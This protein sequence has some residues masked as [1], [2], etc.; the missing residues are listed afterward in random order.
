MTRRYIGEYSSTSGKC[1]FINRFFPPPALPPSPI[2]PPF[3]R[4]RGEGNCQCGTWMMIVGAGGGSSGAPV[5]FCRRFLRHHVRNGTGTLVC[6]PSVF[7]YSVSAACSFASFV[8]I[9]LSAAEGAAPARAS[10]RET[11]HPEIQKHESK[12]RSVCLCARA[13]ALSALRR[14]AT[15]Q[16]N[17]P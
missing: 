9:D 11:A 2:S 7:L 6:P 10:E 1:F 4:P 14:T 17:P 13:R 5:S 3:P 8:A 16:K 15:V 12:S